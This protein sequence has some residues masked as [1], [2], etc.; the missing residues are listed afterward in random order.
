[1]YVEI[2]TTIAGRARDRYAVAIEV[3]GRLKYTRRA[4]EATVV[5]VRNRECAK[6]SNLANV[7]H[8]GAIPTIRRGTMN[9]AKTIK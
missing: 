2:T 1:M 8:A 6:W 9:G 5:R 7:V 3:N 4:I